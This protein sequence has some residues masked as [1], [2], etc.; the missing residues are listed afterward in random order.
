MKRRILTLHDDIDIDIE[1]MYT[2]FFCMSF[3]VIVRTY[4]LIHPRKCGN[5]EEV[6][7]EEEEGK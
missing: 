1:M 2:I 6:D 4:I 7:D 3:R 5:E